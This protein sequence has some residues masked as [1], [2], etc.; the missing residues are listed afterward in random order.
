V[1]E[2]GCKPKKISEEWTE[3]EEEKGD[4]DIHLVN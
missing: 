1:G 3:E 4:K 2:G